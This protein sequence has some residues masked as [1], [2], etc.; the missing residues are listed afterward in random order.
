M[1]SIL[2]ILRASWLSATSYR[3]ATL[4]SFAGLLASVVPVYFITKAVEPMARESI[5]LEG[6]EY[7]GFV[8]VG[9]AATHILMA[10][11]S[12][13]PSVLAG[14]IG[15]GTFESLTVTRTSL[16]V[17]LTGMAAYPLLQS[18]LRASLLLGGAVV[19]GV[20]VEWVMLP[21][22]AVILLLMIAAYAAIGLVAAS[23]VLVFRTSGPLITAVVAGSGLLGG[24]YYSTAVIPGWLQSLSAIIPL[25][26][27]L[28][29]ARRLLLGHATM[30][31]VAND[32][33][34]LAIIAVVGLALG[35]LVFAVALRYA[36]SAG[37]LSQ[38]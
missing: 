21:A 30:G 9:I 19:I 4:I 38:Y 11:A 5:R 10:A 1:N 24:V 17:L 32:V 16:P 14:S 6:G 18:L 37:T 33:A 28:R 3:L 31:A 20:K 23:L 7:F 34:V 26:Y 8:I 29:A 15:S 27:A 12:A 22:V 36:R 13:I 2:A 35:S 25:T